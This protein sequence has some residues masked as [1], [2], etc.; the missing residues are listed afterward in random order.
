MRLE[1]RNEGAQMEVTYD[2]NRKEGRK[3]KVSIHW[4]STDQIRPWPPPLRF[5]NHAELDTW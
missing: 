5:L 1:Y 3:N 4:L 2:Q